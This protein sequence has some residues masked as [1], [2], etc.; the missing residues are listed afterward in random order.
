MESTNSHCRIPKQVGEDKTFWQQHI[1]ACAVSG[2]SKAAYC[3]AN[4]VDY[5]R[6]IYWSKKELSPDSIV[7]LVAVKLSAGQHALPSNVSLCTL[8]LKNGY[9]LHVHDA[10]VLPVILDRLV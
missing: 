6:F 7:P 8:Q 3:H 5:A 1:A 9:H 10:R 2:I 4:Q